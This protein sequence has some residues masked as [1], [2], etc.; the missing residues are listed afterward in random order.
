MKIFIGDQGDRAFLKSLAQ[1]LPTIDILIDDGGHTTEQQIRTYEALFPQVA[2]DNDISS[3]TCTPRTG[4]SSAVATADVAPS[5]T[6][7][8]TLSMRRMR[9]TRANQPG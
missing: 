7:A 2:P 5:S 9:G 1:T 3:R 6:T 8:R 4:A